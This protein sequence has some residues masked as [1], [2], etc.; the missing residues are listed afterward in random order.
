MSWA[1][2]YAQSNHLPLVHHQHTHKNPSKIVFSKKN[3][4]LLMEEIPAPV[5]PSGCLGF[6]N[7]QQYHGRFMSYLCRLRS[8]TIRPFRLHRNPPQHLLTGFPGPNHPSWP[9]PH[10]NFNLADFVATTRTVS[11]W[12]CCWKAPKQ[13]KGVDRR[14][15]LS[16]IPLT[17]C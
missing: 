4:I 5:I 11:W 10:V 12:D 3:T 2:I 8:S 14:Y 7:H 16:Y 1:E 6:L 17:G 13:R 15:D 9:K